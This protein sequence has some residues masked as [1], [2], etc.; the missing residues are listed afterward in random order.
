MQTRKEVINYTSDS[1]S[2]TYEFL[3]Y[4]RSEEWLTEYPVI[5]E[6]H[7]F[8]LNGSQLISYCLPFSY[9][10]AEPEYIQVVS[11][12]HITNSAQKQIKNIAIL[13]SQHKEL[14]LAYLKQ[15]SEINLLEQVIHKI[16]HQFGNSLSLIGL[17]AHNLYLRL[18]SQS[19]RDEAKI[20]HE[21]IQELGNNLTD[22]INCSQSERL[23]I[24]L[25]DLRSI[26]L[27]SIQ[28]LQ[29]LI[30]EKDLIISI[31]DISAKLEVD[32]LQ[33]KHVFDNI[34][35][36]AVHFSPGSGKIVCTWQE[37][38]E[39]IFIQIYDEG[40]GISSEDLPQIFNPFYSRRS[41][42]TGLGLTIARKIVLDHRGSI[43]ARNLSTGGAEFCLVL[44]R[45]KIINE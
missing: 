44:P 8:L 21:R 24:S 23:K 7:E 27:E 13:L 25:Q 35:S 26:V 6:L 10:N 19:Y 5:G 29:P 31:P 4:L 33:I 34:F 18:Q 20:I 43:W 9:K 39:E 2:F 38:K 37:F 45:K 32:R 28:D 15:K 14:Y 12:T 42:G 11:C 40:G 22:I 1:S 36:N 17:Y 30:I 41:G 16:V 3:D